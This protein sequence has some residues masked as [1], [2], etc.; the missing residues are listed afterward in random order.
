MPKSGK[1]EASDILEGKGFAHISMS[2]LLM[3][4]IM[5]DQRL[6]AHEI[7][8]ALMLT[9]A[10][11][12]RKTEPGMLARLSMEAISQ[13][14]PNTKGAI[15]DGIRNLG[16]IETLI[17]MCGERGDELHLLGVKV[18]DDFEI[19]C[20]IRFQRLEANLKQRN[21]GTFDPPN[22]EAFKENSRLEWDDPDPAGIHVKP[23]LD[24]IQRRSFGRILENGLKKDGTLKEIDEWRHDIN[25]YAASLEGQT[26]HPEK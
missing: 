12:Y 13:L 14:H 7:N 9:S 25:E 21:D 6:K 26:H 22:W 2:S 24:D 17:S 1:G 23:C 3:G 11:N 10:R 18:S 4:Q 8:R 5:K 16:E 20:K 15:V 19:D